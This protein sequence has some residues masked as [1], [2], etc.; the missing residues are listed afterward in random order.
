M[1]PD[2]YKVLPIPPLPPTQCLNTTTFTQPKLDGSLSVP[3]LYDWHLEHSPNHPLFVFSDEQGIPTTIYWPEAARAV[4]RA[5]H[6]VRSLVHDDT[7]KTAQP[8]KPRVL[9]VLAATG[10]FVLT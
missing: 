5:G 2:N 1:S 4:H 3:E 7:S 9:A 10:M 6:L 8:S